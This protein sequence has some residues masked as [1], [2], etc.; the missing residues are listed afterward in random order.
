MLTLFEL[1]NLYYTITS[2]HKNLL[3]NLFDFLGPIHNLDPKVFS[4]PPNLSQISP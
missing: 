1:V 3:I 2:M 4:P